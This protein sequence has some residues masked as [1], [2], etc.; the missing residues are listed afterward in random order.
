[1]LDHLE[2]EVSD[3]GASRRFYGAALAPLGYALKVEGKSLGFG[4]ARAKDF[5]IKLG[6]PANRPLHYAFNCSSREQVRAGHAAA[7]QGGGRVD[8][9]PA[10]LPA[11]H[12]NYYAGFV[13]DPDGNSIEFVSHTPE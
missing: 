3:L 12:P 7:I 5:W 4:D 6:V 2:V 9:A 8:R 11:I 13:F 1:M 10:L